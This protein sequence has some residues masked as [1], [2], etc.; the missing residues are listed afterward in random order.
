VPVEGCFGNAGP[1]NEF[2]N[3]DVADASAGEKFVGNSK[4]PVHRIGVT[5]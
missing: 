5:G 4:D 2:V 1:F 3:A